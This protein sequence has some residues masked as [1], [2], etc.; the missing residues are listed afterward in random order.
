MVKAKPAKKS[1]K[2]L[3]KNKKA[4]FDYE[5]LEQIEAGIQ[6]NGSEVKSCKGGK[7]NLKGAFV[8]VWSGEA[9]VNEMHISRYKHS[10]QKDLSPTRKRKLLLHKKEIEK[11]A[12]QLNEKGTAVIPL[13]IYLKG[14][15]IKLLIGVCRGKKKFDKR[16]TL[17]KKA[18]ELEIK[19]ALKKFSRQ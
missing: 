19:R 16:E 1:E 6:L 3:A 7:A 11:L 2:S 5:I 10:S 4:Y 17:K 9:F 18:Q 8:D 15:I 14:G 12:I 13:E